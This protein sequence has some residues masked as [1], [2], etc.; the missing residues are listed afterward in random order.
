MIK[1]IVI[2][3]A[4][5]VGKTELSIKLAKMFNGEII[6]AD[7]SQFRKNLNIGTAKIKE[8]EKEGVIHHL[9]D[10]L[11]ECDNFSI[12]EYQ[13]TARAKIGEISKKGKVPIIVG[14]SGL[15]ID[16]LLNDYDL[17]GPSNDYIDSEKEYG[18][19]SN[20]ELFKVLEDI[21][22]EYA[23]HTHPNNRKR[24]IRYIQKAKD[25]FEFENSKPSKHY[26]YLMLFLNRERVELY[27]RIN[28]RTLLMME[29]GWIDEVKELR[30]RNVDINLIKEI[31]YKEINNYLDGLLSYDEM[32][33]IIQKQ[34]RHYAKRQITWF[35]NKS[36]SIV[37]DAN[38]IDLEYIK[39]LID[40][41]FD[42]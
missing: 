27:E 30:E 35:K 25:G 26:D 37:V 38:N 12:K 9:F 29:N 32:I 14:G 2:A 16:A 21:N 17:S 7:A 10:F 33:D 28:K 42:K 24:V 3:G 6:N 22:P 8:E 40:E 31:G 20:E 13:T 19:Y 34:T 41:H 36:D 1:V 23:S 5:G 4:T 15:Y 11:D 39:G 18:I